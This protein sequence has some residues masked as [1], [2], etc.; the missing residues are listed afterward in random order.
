MTHVI[1]TQGNSTFEEFVRVNEIQEQHLTRAGRDGFRI[2]VQI[3][4][5]LQNQDEDFLVIASSDIVLPDGWLKSVSERMKGVQSNWKSCVA[6]TAV[7]AAPFKHGY[8]ATYLVD[9]L[10]EAGYQGVSRIETPVTSSSA[11]FVVLDLVTLRAKLPLGFKGFSNEDFEIW[12][13]LELALAG[14]HVLSSPAMATYVPKRRR[15]GESRSQPE[16]ELIEFVSQNVNC[17]EF[18]TTRGKVRIPISIESNLRKVPPSINELFL[19]GL[20]MAKSAPRLAIVI[21]TQ[22]KRPAELVRCLESVLS[23]AAQYNEEALNLVLVSDSPKPLKVEVPDV[24]E[25][26]T[27]KV[28]EGK[29]S[30]FILVGEAV[31]RINSD[32]Y[33]FVDDDD[34]MF[35]NNAASLRRLIRVCPE[36][37]VVFADA[38][39]YSEERNLDDSIYVGNTVLPGRFF[40]GSNFPGSLTGVNNNPFCAVVFPRATF[41]DLTPET[42]SGVEYAEDYFLILRT[43]YKDCPPVVLQGEL[44]GISIRESGNTVTEFGHLKWLRAKA[45]VAQQLANSKGLSSGKFLTSLLSEEGSNR[46]LIQR[47]FRVIFDGRLLRF[48]IQSDV[49]GKMLRGEVSIRYVF[50]KISGLI[51]RGW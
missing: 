12:F 5:L 30:R 24:F 31:S 44:V 6:L 14:L 2:S 11:E 19:G 28:P 33:L 51:R 42:Y 18:R 23:F 22:F 26:V 7:G 50:S 4:S 40:P 29:D 41:E 34:W 16:R 46:P 8:S 36:G 25:F 49:L 47:I 35:P 27:V 38:R 3:N 37:S 15:L 10:V 17:K 1:V 9:H 39:H 45:N 48:A 13:S 21:R 20:D 32:Y 43:L